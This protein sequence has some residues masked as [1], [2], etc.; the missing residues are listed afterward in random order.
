MPGGFEHFFVEMA[1]RLRGLG[2]P[3]TPS[4]MTD[5]ARPLWTQYGVETVQPRGT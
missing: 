5:V 3:P 2:H 4:D 1:D